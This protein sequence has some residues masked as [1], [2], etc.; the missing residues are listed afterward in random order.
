MQGNLVTETKSPQQY[1]DAPA[2]QKRK[3]ERATLSE[4][5]KK[6]MQSINSDAYNGIDLFEGTEPM[7]NY[8]TQEP[9]AGAPNLGNPKDAGVDISSLLGDASKIWQAMK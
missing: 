3:K 7:N 6:L 1:T 4:H 8:E 9:K 2:Q 5:R